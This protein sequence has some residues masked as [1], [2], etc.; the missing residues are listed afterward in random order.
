MRK[1]KI[2]CTI[3][4]V[5]KEKEMIKKLV[6][7]GANLFR[8]NFSHASHEFCDEVIDEI[9]KIEKELNTN[10]G[11][12]LDITGPSLR[13]SNLK[14]NEACLTKDKEI[15]IYNYEVLGTASQLSFN[16]PEVVGYLRIKDKILLSDGTIEL[17]VIKKEKNAV[18]A[19]ILNDGFIYSNKAVHV[20]NS[21]YQIPFISDKDKEDIIYAIEKNVDFIALS[22]VR[23]HDDVLE[24]IDLLISLKNDQINLIAKIETEVAFDDIDDILKL[25]DGVMVA[26]GDLGLE[27]PIEKLPYVQKK[28]LKKALCNYKIG[29]VATDMLTSME[30]SSMPTRAEVSDVYNAV[31]DGADAV[32]LCNETTVGNYPLETLDM[33]GK[34]IESA[35]EDYDYMKNLDE[36]MSTEKQ[37][38]T[39]TISYAVVNS[40]LRLR[41]KAIVASTNSGYTARKISRFRP[42]CPIIATSPN[43]DTVRSLTLNYGV[44]PYLVDKEKT[45]DDIIKVCKKKVEETMNLEKSDKYI[46]TGG[47]P[48]SINNTNF[49][50]IEE[51]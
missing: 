3:G 36:I 32:M 25:C 31:I 37:D 22:N 15:K 6:L 23:T 30:K 4:P 42:I 47:F 12:M 13:I 8:I 51:K 14:G 2:I 46:I 43:L 20:S 5:T 9:R 38:I 26:R 21:S 48:S 34:I 41:T 16:H 44:Y 7:G 35:E 33:M 27:M 50:R 45:T 11:I 39:T 24:V 10:I 28:V 29:I 18:I 1:T 40:A 17:E 19:K 49:M